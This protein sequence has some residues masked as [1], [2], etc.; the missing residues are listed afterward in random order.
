M[1]ISLVVAAQVNLV[2]FVM[3]L[4]VL[5]LNTHVSYC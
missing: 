4:L 3:V 1:L 2:L 5:L